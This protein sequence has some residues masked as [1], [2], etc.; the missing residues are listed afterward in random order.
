MNIA[1]E[2]RALHAEM[3]KASDQWLEDV[4]ALAAAIL[5]DRGAGDERFH[6]VGGTD[7]E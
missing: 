7:A 1:D 3:S 6:A 2:H 4:I 5:R